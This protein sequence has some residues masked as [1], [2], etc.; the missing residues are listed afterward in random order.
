VNQYTD[1]TQH[2]FW[3]SSR[4][5]GIVAIILLAASVSMGLLMSSR[6][7]SKRGF[8]SQMK[9]YHEALALSAMAAIAAHGLTLL[10]DKFLDPGLSGVAL[11]FAMN[12]QPVWTGLG[13]IGAW[14]TAIFT[15][16]FYVRSWIG[17]KT[18]RW[19]H[20]WTLLAYVLAVVHTV[21]SGTDGGSA[22]ML[23][24]LAAI[25]TPVVFGLALKAMP[26]NRPAKRARG[27]E[28]LA[29]SGLG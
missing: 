8:A 2:L 4:A 22:W 13:I 17:T 21:G 7:I 10:G 26:R 3:L 27:N 29:P 1:P 15:F 28:Q 20:R 14:L 16:S 25:T 11:P 23:V 19:L 6:A 5:L 9:N 18:W 12:D 24:L